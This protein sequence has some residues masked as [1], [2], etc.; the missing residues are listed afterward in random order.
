MNTNSLGFS[1]IV[2]TYNGANRL[3]PTL[4]NIFNQNIPDGVLCELI[5]V[6][7]NSTDNTKEFAQELVKKFNFKDKFTYLNESR[8]GLN[9]AVKTGIT[10]AKYKWVLL[11]DDDNH[12]DLNY[13]EIGSRILATNINIGALGGVGI[14]LFE[15][16][17]PSWFDQYSGSF[18]IGAQNNIDG[19]IESK[20][21]AIYGAGSFLRRDILLRFYDDGFQTIMSDRS[22][23]KLTSGGDIERCF[24]IQ[25]AGFD[26]WFDKSLVFQHL[27]PNGRMNWPYYLRLKAG[28]A[29]GE[30]LL[31]VY[32]Q[33]LENKNLNTVS[34]VFNY[35]KSFIFNILVF[36]KFKLSSTLNRSRYSSDTLDLGNVILPA[37]IKS[38]GNNI[39]ICI[40]HF[41]QIKHYL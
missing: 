31:S 12:L 18:A 29:S 23:N 26:I 38:Y 2:C 17:K 28:I 11:C 39:N 30:A 14:P 24:L 25:L 41:R 6:D 8:Q 19:K 5:L 10:A 4:E 13:I 33:I 40:R 1:I 36:I 32:K 37:K 7:N 9:Y 21:A 3:Q 16:T 35:F 22:G 15:S 27:M 20:C 34:F